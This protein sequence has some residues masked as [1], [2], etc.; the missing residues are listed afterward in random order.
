MNSPRILSTGISSLFVLGG[1]GV[2][3]VATRAAVYTWDGGGADTSLSN[4]LNWSSDLIPDVTVNDTALWDGTVAGPLALIYGDAAFA[5]VA[6]NTGIDF[7][8]ASTQTSSLNIDSGT[9]TN[10]LRMNNLSIAAGAGAF[11][12]GNGPGR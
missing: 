4:P 11:S 2:S 5:G 1:L 9:N 6:G 7:S 3:P 10:S 12:F 8:I